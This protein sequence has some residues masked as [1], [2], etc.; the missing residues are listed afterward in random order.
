MKGLQEG[1]QGPQGLLQLL[2][3]NLKNLDRQALQTD[4]AVL[5]VLP[6]FCRGREAYYIY[7]RQ[8]LSPLPKLIGHK[9]DFNHLL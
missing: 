8:G 3:L 1:A 2:P 5:R 4:S 6:P 9:I 7:I